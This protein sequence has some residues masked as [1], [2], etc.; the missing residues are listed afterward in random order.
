MIV[1]FFPH[2]AE[3]SGLR[4]GVAAWWMSEITTVSSTTR[5]QKKSVDQDSN[6][7]DSDH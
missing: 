6:R 3:G 1:A 4:E 7:Q 2:P 5:S